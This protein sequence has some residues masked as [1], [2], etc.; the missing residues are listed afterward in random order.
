[1]PRKR[2][3]QHWLQSDRI[4]D[5]I[6]EAADLKPEETVLEIGP[7]KGALTHRL[8]DV[9]KVL[10]VEIDRDLCKFLVKKFGNNDNFLLLQGDILNL[11]IQP[12][13]KDFPN[14]QY[15]T[16]VVANIPY[17][18]TGPILENLLGTI[19]NPALTNYESIVLLIQKEVGDRLVAKPGSRDFGALT[20]R[21]QYL[22]D[23]E[24]IC[25]VPAK[26]FYPPPKV[27]SVVVRLT[28]RKIE[29]PANN[30]K[31]LETLVKVGFSSKRKMLKNNLKSLINLEQLEELLTV[32]NIKYEARGE[33]LSLIDWINLSNIFPQD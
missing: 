28:P 2:F 31:L 12:L 20:V 25:D 7:G 33:E 22:A 29:T 27:D 1:M 14:F 17:N 11:D 18:I 24:L 23:C 26:C 10:A 13:I 30:P 21:V 32:L 19:S 5:K 6:V 15:P 9:V 16:K 4:L 3:G 8:L